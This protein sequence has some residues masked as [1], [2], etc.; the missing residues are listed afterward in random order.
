VPVNAKY[1]YT[2]Q[3]FAY[4]GSTD[5]DGYPTGDGYATP[6]ARP[7][8]DIYPLSSQLNMTGDYDRRVITS[9]VMQVPDVSP[10]SARDKVVVPGGAEY[11]VSEDV[12]DYSTGPFTF[13][14]SGDATHFGEVVLEVVAG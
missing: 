1:K 4:T 11:I 2:V 14:P 7:A 3:H 8:Y 12:R 13:R 10:Y 9:K 5:S 6:V